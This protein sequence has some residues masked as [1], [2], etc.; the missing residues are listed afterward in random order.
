MVGLG[1][2]PGDQPASFAS[3]VSA[4]GSVIVG[5]HSELVTELAVRWVD[6]VIESLG[7]LPGGSFYPSS[8]A[9]DVSSDGRVVVG[10]G[11]SEIGY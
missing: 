3:A 9:R 6:G 4:D 10:R 1:H 5:L 8:R 2:L 11:Q 7:D